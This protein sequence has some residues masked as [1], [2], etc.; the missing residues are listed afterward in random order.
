MAHI[1]DRHSPLTSI[2]RLRVYVSSG[3]HRLNEVKTM[4]HGCMLLATL[5]HTQWNVVC[6][7]NYESYTTCV[8]PSTDVNTVMVSYAVS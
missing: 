8:G 3:R 6:L 7:F 5:G 4:F 2:H 1:S